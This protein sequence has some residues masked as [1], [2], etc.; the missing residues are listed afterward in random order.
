ML[1]QSDMQKYSCHCRRCL[2]S[3]LE[4]YRIRSGAGVLLCLEVVQ[5]Q[6]KLSKHSVAQVFQLACMRADL[7]RVMPTQHSLYTAANWQHTARVVP[8]CA[9]HSLPRH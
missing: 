7:S 4:V 1:A 6:P 2:S 3:L 9:V 5:G 8:L